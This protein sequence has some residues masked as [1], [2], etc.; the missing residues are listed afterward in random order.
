MYLELATLAVTLFI[1]YHLFFEFREGNLPPGPRPLPLIGNLNLLSNQMHLD[2][3]ALEKTYGKIFRVYLAHKPIIVLSGDAIKEALVRQPRN[4]AG[5]PLLPI[6]EEVVDKKRGK[7]LFAMDYGERWRIFRKLGHST[8]KVYGEDRLQEVI[9]EEVSEL[10]KRLEESDEKPIDITKQFGTAVTNV[11]CTKIF[12]NRYDINDPEF[13]RL[14][15]INDKST[16][17]NI[18]EGWLK[19]AFPFLKPFLPYSQQVKEIK[20][21]DQERFVIMKAKYDEHVQ[22]FDP[23][24][25]RDY[26]DALLK[27]K[28]E[29]EEED[30][31]SKEHFGEGPIIMA[32]LVTLFLAGSETTTT[33]LSWAIAYLLHNPGVQARLHKEIDQVIGKDV[34][35]KLS[36]RTNIPVLEAFTAETQ[37]L[38]NLV[39]LSLP[40]KTT[41]DCTLLGYEIA[42][43]T[44][45]FTNL[46]SLHH[47]PSIWKE[48]DTF[49]LDRFLDAKGKF[50]AP[51]GGTFLPF[52]A[53]PRVCLGEV[54]ARSELFLFLATLLQHF[55]FV[56]PLG[57]PL[58]SL[59]GDMGV[60]L[61][62]KPFTVCVRK[63]RDQ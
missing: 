60:V 23:N 48:P 41:S 15:Y 20:E 30:K 57:C 46:W 2:F 42:K 16:R 37:R 63:R 53:G 25:I 58:P 51:V 47:D 29:A 12:G 50:Q 38:S 55:E 10:C 52:G 19:E 7:S 36:Q 40:H 34:S 17:L 43:G 21:L 45:V 35:P 13:Q 61:H 27:A 33:T 5:R 59:E 3:A 11:I 4:F 1:V 26:T 6:T 8:I 14:Y 22:T 9:N 24:H 39:P 54:L 32:G 31:S 62:P 28:Q 56:N 18:G 44:T 49:N